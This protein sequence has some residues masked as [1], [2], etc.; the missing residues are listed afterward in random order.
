MSE[1]HAVIPIAP[2]A[3]PRP[4]FKQITTGGKKR[5]ITYYPTRYF[6]YM[7]DVQQYLVD[8]Q[9]YNDEFYQTVNAPFGTLAEV[10]F[11]LAVPKNQKQVKS[12][13]RKAAPDID[14][15]QKAILDSIFKDLKVRDS[16]IV[17][18]NAL[19]LNEKD[20]PRTEIKLVGIDR[21]EKD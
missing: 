8:H 4:Q 2:M 7:H 13:L 6:D 14:N 15:L 17:G 19:K 5:T 20:Y 3:T 21:D 10:V 16:R 11:Y 18:I 1:W 12:L 9:L